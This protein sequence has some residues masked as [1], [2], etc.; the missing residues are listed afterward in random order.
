MVLFPAPPVSMP[1]EAMSISNT[2]A[3]LTSTS[4]YSCWSRRL[5]GATWPGR[6]VL[7][8]ADTC[9]GRQNGQR[10]MRTMLREWGGYP[11][12]REGHHP[13]LTR[14]LFALSGE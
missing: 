12:L 9:M 14:A 5:S 1:W 11:G 13:C 8:M 7:E 6:Y 3:S 4:G 10:V 2:A